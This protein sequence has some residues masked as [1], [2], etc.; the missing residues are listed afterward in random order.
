[1]MFMRGVWVLLVMACV[2]GSL[3]RAEEAPAVERTWLDSRI[4]AEERR[5]L[6][7]AIGFAPPDLGEGVRWFGEAAPSWK[8]LQG[9]VVVL[10]T[11]TVSS[12]A[13][14]SAP[15]RAV[16]ALS[17]FNPEDVTLIALH[18]PQGADNVEHF[19]KAKP[20][21]VPV[22]LDEQGAFCDDMG[23]W[24]RPATILI[25]KAGRVRATGVSLAKLTDAVAALRDEALDPAAPP[26]EVVPTRAAA[27][28][29]AP[30]KKGD[31]NYPATTDKV[32][33]T[34]LRG[35]RAPA[36]AAQTWITPKPDTTNK[37]VIVDFWATWCRPC[38]ASIPHMNETQEKFKDSVVIVGLSDEMDTTVRQFMRRTEMKYTVAT[39]SGRR[40]M[41]AFRPSGIPHV[42]II[43]PDGVV[44]WQ[45]HP[46]DMTDELLQRI[47]D[48]SGAGPI[49]A[50]TG[51]PDSDAIRWVKKA[52]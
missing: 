51:L 17:S 30:D 6:D 48:A 40:M 28:Q 37:V 49:R 20:L 29:A 21:N 43:S 33:A 46:A 7:R 31:G 22:A 14:R 39:D 16:E 10:Q 47:I 2:P 12:D 42:A 4:P 9:R 44:R 25:D 23:I 1:M 3:A 11:W 26:P 32:R 41:N 52:R 38:V 15:A 8:D 24:R 50:G 35:K 45:G 19:L 18:T 13:G 27:V 5:M 36:L 34:D